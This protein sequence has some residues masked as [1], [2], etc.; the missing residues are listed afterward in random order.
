MNS[1]IF[2]ERYFL[3]VSFS[4][5]SLFIQEYKC[6]V[7]SAMAD[8][9]RFLPGYE[10][11][12]WDSKYAR[13]VQTYWIWSMFSDIYKQNT[14]SKLIIVL[15]YLP[16]NTYLVSRSDYHDWLW[17]TCCSRQSAF[18]VEELKKEY[19]SLHWRG[20]EC[21]MKMVS[22]YFLPTSFSK[23][24]ILCNSAVNSEWALTVMHLNAI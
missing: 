6:W 9:T 2:I 4:L 17:P 14:Y 12:W 10:R 23:Y 5:F 24:N 11:N 18:Y 8:K 13:R 16:N 20:N 15:T 22:D 21:F 7:L 1:I 3:S 19:R